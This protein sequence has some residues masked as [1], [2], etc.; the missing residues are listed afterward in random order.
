[1][2]G[3]ITNQSK[4][5]TPGRIVVTGGAQANFFDDVANGGSIQ[6]SAAGSLQS[7]AVFLGSLYR[8][9]SQRRR[10]TSSSK[11]TPA[12]ASAPAPWPSAATSASV[13]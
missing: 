11:A 12:P 1:M 13:P 2:F 10:V 5:G 4:L 3:D 7:T 8:K 9:R 6:V